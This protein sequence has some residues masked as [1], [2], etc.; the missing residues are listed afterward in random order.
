MP[1]GPYRGVGR[2]GACFAIE[3]TIDEVARA[4]GRDPVTVRIENM[5]RPA[6][7][8]CSSQPYRCGLD[9]AGSHR[10]LAGNAPPCWLPDRGL[11][12]TDHRRRHQR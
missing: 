10:G 11:A 1:L 6:L 5:I 2:P 12:A 4:V 9:N 3:R 8:P 7:A